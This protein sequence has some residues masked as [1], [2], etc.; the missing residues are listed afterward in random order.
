MVAVTVT[1]HCKLKLVQL[2]GA[3][4]LRRYVHSCPAKLS[5]YGLKPFRQF[6]MVPGCLQVHHCTL[7]V[8]R[9]RIEKLLH[10]VLTRNTS[11]RN[12]QPDMLVAAG[13]QKML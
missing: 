3:F 7:L 6:R 2:R 4:S 10:L 5:I 12:I 8:K 13:K 1:I 9:Q 11:A